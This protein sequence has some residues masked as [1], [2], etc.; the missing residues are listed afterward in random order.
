MGFAL[1]GVAVMAG[2]VEGL[3]REAALFLGGV[4]TVF[5]GA[6][7]LFVWTMSVL[8]FTTARS[9][10]TRKHYTFCFIMACVELINI[11]FGTTLAI[12][13]I[14]VLS[15]PTVRAMFEGRTHADSRLAALDDFD[16]E[17]DEGPMPTPVKKRPG[18]ESIKE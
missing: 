14:V 8:E 15:R 18:D 2:I 12:F 3:D 5:E 6:I 16:E 4:L 11:P 10:A 9:L 17:K 13:T 7:G 1:V